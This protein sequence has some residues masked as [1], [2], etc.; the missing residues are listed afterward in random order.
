MSQKVLL[1]LASWVLA[2]QGC[3]KLDPV[4]ADQAA[5]IRFGPWLLD[6]GS[7]QVT[8]A[9]HSLGDT[10]GK[11][12]YGEAELDRSAVEQQARSEHR[13][14]ISG[15]QADRRYRYRV[16]G[17]APR[18]GS[19]WTAPDPAAQVPFKVLV[20]GDNRTDE[21]AHA[22]V[23]KAAVKEGARLALHTGDMVQDAKKA[24]QWLSWF[25]VEQDLLRV[26]PLLA[27][28]GNHEL[29]DKGV[30]YSAHFQSLGH[31]PYRSLDFGPVHVV[32]LDAFELA[33]GAKTPRVGSIGWAQ[34]AW[35]AQDLAAVPK[36]RHVWLLTHQGPFS[37]AAPKAK[38]FHGGSENVKEALLPFKDRIQ[39][40]FAGH[41][42][43]YQRG[44]EEGL[45]YFVVGGGGAPLYDPD[46][47]APGVK[48]A[49]KSHS[50]LAL[51][52]CGCHVTGTVKDPAGQVLDS[53][54]LAS[55][56]TACPAVPAQAA[57]R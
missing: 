25:T 40:V 53:F 52:V 24:E 17:P 39:A 21:L 42:H 19:F 51:D 30:A 32:V 26:T 31:A 38:K 29:G 7:S 12:S 47:K 8:V 22:S 11:V 18:E 50:Y 16:E 36:D 41:D 44:E 45:R 56:P 37:H 13:V 55:C 57:Q 49:K 5:A 48:A 14:L 33:P 3:K 34:R 43:Y 27:T 23:V 35:L 2:A 28:V 20:Y 4:S 46:D 6:V 9:W 10:A 1:L 54:T 15:L